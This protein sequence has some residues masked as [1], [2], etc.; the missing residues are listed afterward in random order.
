MVLTL[1]SV[2]PTICF[3]QLVCQLKNMFFSGAMCVYNEISVCNWVQT[4]VRMG[5]KMVSYSEAHFLLEM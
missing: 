2:I 5:V 3:A 4:G 1:Q